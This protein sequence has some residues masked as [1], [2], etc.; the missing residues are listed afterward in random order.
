MRKTLIT[1]VVSWPVGFGT[2]TRSIQHLTSVQQIHQ[3]Q[4]D[5]RDRIR[6]GGERV[7]DWI[8]NDFYIVART[9]LG[10][11]L[12]CVTTNTTECQPALF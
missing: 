2:F 5:W 3:I 11:L 6:D 4:L 8:L 10:T 9:N 12:L 7:S 1:W